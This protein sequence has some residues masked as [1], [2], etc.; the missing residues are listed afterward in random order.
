MQMSWWAELR[1]PLLA[2]E[3]A[4]HGAVIVSDA[5]SFNGI[6]VV[7]GFGKDDVRASC[8]RMRND[9]MMARRSSQKD[10]GASRSHHLHHWGDMKPIWRHVHS[11][12]MRIMYYAATRQWCLYVETSPIYSATFRLASGRSQVYGFSPL[13]AHSW[14]AVHPDAG[15]APR[16][17]PLSPPLALYE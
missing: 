11:E 3:Y 15:A 9:L 7:Q 10:H 13:Q 4:S 5:G 6:Y 1:A 16:S 8:G 17:R 2:L 14:Q 12:H